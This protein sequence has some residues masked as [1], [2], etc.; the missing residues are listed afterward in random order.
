MTLALTAAQRSELERLLRQRQAQLD[1]QMAEH[2]GGA[3]R[4]QHAREVLL[5]DGDDAPQRDADREVELARSD[6]EMAEL[7]RVSQAL[8]RVH[9]PEFGFCQDCG[10]AIPFA[11]LSLEPWALRCV[12]CERQAEGHQARRT[13]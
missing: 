5:Q 3:S 9:S 2:Q 13:L 8:Q 10:D 1:Q 11:R 4:V 7:G 6:R 12:G